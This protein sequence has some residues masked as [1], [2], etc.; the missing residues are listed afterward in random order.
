MKLESNSIGLDR[1]FTGKIQGGVKLEMEEDALSHDLDKFSSKGRRNQI[2]EDYRVCKG[3][4]GRTERSLDALSLM[5][6]WFA[7]QKFNRLRWGIDSVLCPRRSEVKFD[8][9]KERYVIRQRS[10]QALSCPHRPCNNLF[11]TLTNVVWC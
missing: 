10:T 9:G 6:T 5:H 4:S 11:P 7:D 3:R 2:A 8:V 1:F